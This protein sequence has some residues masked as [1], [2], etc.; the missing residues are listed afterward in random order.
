VRLENTFVPLSTGAEKYLDIPQ[1]LLELFLVPR[2][3]LVVKFNG[4]P[5]PLSGRKVQ[6]W[7]KY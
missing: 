3:V 7:G 6:N 5:I 2:Q 4:F 1:T